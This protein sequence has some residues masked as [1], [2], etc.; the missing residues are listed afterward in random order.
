MKQRG[1]WQALPNGTRVLATVHPSYV[2][3]Q[4]DSGSRHAAYE[5]FVRDLEPL[6]GL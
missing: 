4:R 1:Q 5:A 3:R 2:L 6:A